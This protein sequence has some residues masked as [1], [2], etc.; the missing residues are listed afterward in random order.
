[1]SPWSKFKE[2]FTRDFGGML[3]L[4]LILIAFRLVY[5][6][7]MSFVETVRAAG[8]PLIA[9]PGIKLEPGRYRPASGLAGAQRRTGRMLMARSS[10]GL[11]VGSRAR[12]A[13]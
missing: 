11:A 10:P 3:T 12:S 5:K 2:R 6:K 4:S 9:I 13:A 1:M 7:D 8:L